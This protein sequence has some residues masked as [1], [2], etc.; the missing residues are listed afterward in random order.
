MYSS[1][2]VSLFCVWQSWL[3]GVGSP[4]RARINVIRKRTQSLETSQKKKKKTNSMSWRLPTAAYLVPQSYLTLL[5]DVLLL[6]FQL[7]IRAR[8][9]DVRC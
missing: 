5:E 4:L 2:T 8:L 9:Y 3:T 1:G 6:D 7:I